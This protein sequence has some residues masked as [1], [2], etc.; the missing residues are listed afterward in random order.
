E[1]CTHCC[2]SQRQR[3]RRIDDGCG[4]HSDRPGTIPWPNSDG[5]SCCA[6]T[7][8]VAFECSTF[9]RGCRCPAEL[10]PHGFVAAS[11]FPDF[12]QRRPAAARGSA[13][14][15]ATVAFGCGTGAFVRSVGFKFP[16][17]NR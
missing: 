10:A 11:K 4:E 16:V 12:L 14:T 3:W 9:V 13:T 7:C 15:L 6:G 1:P 17:C 5:G 2:R 8:G